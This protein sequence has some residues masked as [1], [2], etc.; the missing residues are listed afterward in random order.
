MHHFAKVNFVF[1]TSL[2]YPFNFILFVHI[3]PFKQVVDFILVACKALVSFI[4]PLNL[5]KRK[6]MLHRNVMCMFKFLLFVSSQH[7]PSLCIC[8][9]DKSVYLCN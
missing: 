5:E 6:V 3:G 7:I 8:V 4:H 1:V 9:T 2:A